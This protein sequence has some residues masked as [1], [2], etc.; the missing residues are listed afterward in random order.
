VQ[1]VASPT[2]INFKQYVDGSPLTSGNCAGSQCTLT[3]LS[4]VNTAIPYTATPNGGAWL[5][6]GSSFGSVSGTTPDK[7]SVVASAARGHLSAGT[8]SGFVEVTSSLATNSPLRV[9]VTLTVV[10]FGSLIVSPASLGF[11]V[12]VGETTTFEQGIS[13]TST[14]SP[15]EAAFI[16][17]GEGGFWLST[18]VSPLT[19]FTPAN[20]AVDVHPTGLLVGTYNGTVTI[21]P[22]TGTGLG[23]GTAIVVPVTLTVVP[24]RITVSPPQLNF[25]YQT[26]GP[27][28]LTQTLLIS[29]NTILPFN[30][31]PATSSGG[32]WLSVNPTSGTTQALITVS[33]LPLNLPVGSYQGTITVSGTNGVLG[34]SVIPVGLTVMGP[35]P[36]ITSIVNAASFSKQF[37][38]TP[39]QVVSIFGTAIGPPVP[40]EL[41]LDASGKV[42][43]SLGN[44]QVL[45]GGQPAPLTYVSSTQINCVIPYEIIG[46]TSSPISVQVKNAGQLSNAFTLLPINSASPGIFATNGAGQAAALNQDGSPNGPAHP[47]LAGN[48]VSVFMTGEGQTSPPGITGSVTCKSGCNTLQQIP[49]PLLP[50]TALVS[51]QPAMVTFAG[52]APGLVAGVLQVNLVIPPNTPSGAVPLIIS[53]G[54]VQSQAGVT[55][56]VK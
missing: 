32:N 47:E 23:L 22:R 49:V 29:G 26:G 44:V 10:N 36:T 52:E 45:F 9:P 19:G 18:S 41:Q 50:V 53:V 6:I 11:Q 35:L 24:A 17:G 48:I 2:A 39:G 25:A 31:Q 38:P 30:A 27:V 7:I 33:V 34:S 40:Q 16:A 13:V 4:A 28:P 14:T 55:L 20:I 5:T 46:V 54:G 51:N 12:T 21:S 37:F 8:Y 42:S 56:S 3:L 1:L 43:T 15:I